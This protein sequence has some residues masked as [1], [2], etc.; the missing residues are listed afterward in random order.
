MTLYPADFSHELVDIIAD[1]EHVTEHYHLP[2]QSGSNEILRR[3]NRG[4]SREEY[5]ELTE[6]IHTRDPQASITTDIIVGFPGEDR[7]QFED[8]LDLVEEVQFDNAFTFIYSPREGTAAARWADDTPRS[9]KQE[10]LEE[11]MKLQHSISLQKNRALEGKQVEV[12]IEGPSKKEATVLSSRTRTNK[13]VL[14]PV[15]SAETR[16]QLTG[17]F[18]EVR[19]VKGNTWTLEGQLV[20]SAAH[21]T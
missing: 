1:S 15:D 13:L 17:E 14:I 5:L 8:T 2:V 21:L 12:L 19:I 6:Y 4:Y 3:M 7:K 18:V 10:R 20:T 11:L 16:E 9:V